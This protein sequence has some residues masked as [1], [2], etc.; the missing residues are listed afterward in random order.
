M[1]LSQGL[2]RNLRAK[3]GNRQAPANEDGRSIQECD[4]PD[5]QLRQ[6]RPNP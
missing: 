5:Q 6:L 1:G 4:V 3:F 2:L